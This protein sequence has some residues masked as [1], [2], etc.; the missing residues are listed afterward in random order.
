[1]SKR[2]EKNQNPALFYF[3]AHSEIE[4]LETQTFLDLVERAD[5]LFVECVYPSYEIIDKFEKELNDYSQN[6][7]STNEF[8]ANFLT[9]AIDPMWPFILQ[10]TKGSDKKYA[11]ERTIT[12]FFDLNVLKGES[13][14]AFFLYNLDTSLQMKRDFLSESCEYHI[15]REKDVAEQ[16]L[17]IPE[18]TL[19]LFGT[20]HPELEKLVEHHRTTEIHYP[21]TEYITGHYI[22]QMHQKFRRTGKI[23]PELYLRAMMEGIVR[24]ALDVIH[25]GG[26]DMV[27]LNFT[28]HHYA[29]L[30]SPDQI[31]RYKDNLVS[32]FKSSAGANCGDIF[33]SYLKKESLPPVE[34][35]LE[36]VRAEKI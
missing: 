11:L 2:K 31:V 24:K 27:D 9:D 12:N 26:L 23:E 20:G 5:V 35:V 8:R 21:Y 30:F 4:E 14:S 34:Q 28:I 17:D 16:I 22:N 6:G 10:S 36:K 32:C 15:E 7:I 25:G 13:D 33:E 19:V 1:M 29:A 18:T 3:W